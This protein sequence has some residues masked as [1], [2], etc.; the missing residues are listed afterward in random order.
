MIKN[1]GIIGVGGVGGYFGG[2]LCQAASSDQN[3]FF[4]AR[5]SHLEAIQKN[6]LTLNT[7]NDGNFTCS[8]A[9]ASEDIEQFPEIDLC[10]LTVKGFDLEKT[11]KA[12]RK[13]VT[14]NT[15][16]LPLLNGINID[17]RVRE[18]LP[19]ST[20]FPSCAYISSHIEKPGVVVQ[21]G[22]TCSIIFG[23][24]PAHPA[25]LPDE[26]L[27]LFKKADVN[28][29][30]VEDPT[31]T[32]WEKFIFIAPFSL[33]TACFDKSIGEVIASPKLSRYVRA[34]M[35][36]IIQL[37]DKMGIQ[38]PGDIV[39]TIFGKA[40]N[41]P[42]DTRTSFQ[43]DFSKPEKRDEREIFGRTLLRLCKKEGI[44]CKTTG[45]IYQKLRE[46]KPSRV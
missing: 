35:N 36:E 44:T 29:Q 7:I 3:I 40:E 43:N 12:L 16:I 2:K 46:I 22:G 11:L 45:E 4:L 18:I 23:K 1:I 20:V 39:T 27:Q 37:A 17:A 38:L 41:F 24:D 32:I 14:E 33:V 15:L 28:H 42:A 19:H 6:G 25:A 5:G 13:R 31:P 10:I 21:T 8:S 34:I 9:L 26:I 30:W